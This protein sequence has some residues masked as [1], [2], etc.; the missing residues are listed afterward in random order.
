MGRVDVNGALLEVVDK[1]EGEPLVLVHGSTSD[2]RNWEN[3]IEPFSARFRTIAYSRR[4]HWPNER[5][6]ADKEYL[7]DEQIEDLRALIHVLDLAPVH[8][9]GHSFGALLALMAVIREPGI[10][11]SLVLAE[12]PAVRLF[13]SNKPRI[14]ELLP[15]FL[16]RPRTAAA[17]VK[18]GAK[19]LEPATKAFAR[20]DDQEALEIFAKA[21]FGAGGYDDFTQTRKRQV[22]DNASETRAEFLGPGFLPLE[23]SRVQ[24]VE[25]PT[26][27]LNGERSIPL[28]KLLADRLA[29]LLPHVKRAIIPD[30]GHMM[31]EDNPAEF[32]A[33]VLGFLQREEG[34]R[35]ASESSHSR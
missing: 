13:V 14:G 33:A 17:I 8:L 1:G 23:A 2:Y 24:E 7:M 25:T 35:A 32:N 27:L 29:E 22:Q 15:L 12:P 30:A 11:R 18:F 6:P 28:F 26:L 34:A 19:G 4:Y 10:A 5:I 21:V 16:S 20:G 3:Q 9:V 31:P